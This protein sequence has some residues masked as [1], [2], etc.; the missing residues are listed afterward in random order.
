MTE[1]FLVAKSPEHPETEIVCHIFETWDE[2]TEHL[3]VF[4]YRKLGWKH[5]IVT[6]CSIEEFGDPYEEFESPVCWLHR[7]GT[8]KRE[9]SF[10]NGPPGE[11]VEES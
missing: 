3:A 2:D 1:D 11:I 5:I 7:I 9:F 4:V 6:K 8:L 10:V